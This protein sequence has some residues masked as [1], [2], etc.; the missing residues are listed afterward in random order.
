MK[1]EEA[2]SLCPP[3]YCPGAR[4]TRPAILPLLQR[5]RRERLERFF[6]QIKPG[7][8]TFYTKH[9]LLPHGPYQ[10]LPSGK[11]TRNGWQDPIPGMN[12]PPGFGD[13][14]LTQHNQ[15]RLAAPGRLHRSPARA[16]VRADAGERDLRQRADRDHRRPWLCLR[17]RCEGSP[18]GHPLEHRRDRPRAP[19]HQGAR[20][21]AREDERRVRAHDGHR[22][23]DGRHPQLQ[24]ALP[25]RRSLGVLACGQAAA[26]RADDQARLQRHDH[27]LGALD[28]APAP[29]Q[30]PRRSCG[31]SARATSAPSTRASAP[32]A[33]SWGAPPPTWGR[34]GR[35]RCAPRSA[36]P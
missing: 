5:G 32:T 15:Q 22:A 7:S 8:P 18:H 26:V 12:S 29:R 10:Y 33:G 36:A 3:R 28:G 20:P 19:L 13:R 31:C 14:F 6:A 21:A 23:D 25:R 24:D 34:P 4:K 11:Q 30:R 35:E 16:P 17:G 1:S 2:T 27:R 9:V